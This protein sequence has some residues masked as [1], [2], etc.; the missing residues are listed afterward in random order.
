MEKLLLC[1]LAF[2]SLPSAFSAIDMSKKAFVF[3]KESDDSFVR[4]ISQQKQ[5]LKAF[6]V[7]LYV[8][9]D[10]PRGYSIFSYNTRTQDNEILLFK[11]KTGE[12][13]ISVGGT[14]IFFKYPG[15][16]AP[17]HMCITWE[18]VSGIVELWV[19]GKPMVRKSLKRGYSVGWEAN[20]VLGQEQDSFGGNFNK[21]QCLVGEIGD[22]NM[23]DFVLSPGE[24]RS[25]YSGESFSPNVLTWRALAYEMYGEVFTKP[26]LWL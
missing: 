11:E 19:D 8:Y 9:S 5:P 26:R 16:S 1:F 21:E 14:D 25:V 20:I 24:I 7:C 12:Y 15:N 4:L 3:P 2:L 13:S 22:V 6:T 23:W 10:L 18:S 17:L